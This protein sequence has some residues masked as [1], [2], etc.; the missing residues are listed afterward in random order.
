MKGN[1]QQRWTVRLCFVANAG[2]G[3][4]NWRESSAK[5]YLGIVDVQIVPRFVF[6]SRLGIGDVQIVFSSS[7]KESLCSCLRFIP[8]RKTEVQASEQTSAESLVDDARW[9]NDVLPCFREPQIRAETPRAI[10]ELA[11]LL[12]KK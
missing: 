10:L 3:P 11:E 7:M 9:C 5:K 12:G 1:K 4:S 2:R 8:C 6:H